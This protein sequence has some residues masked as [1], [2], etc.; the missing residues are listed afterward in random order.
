MP[1]DRKGVLKTSEL[2]GDLLLSMLPEHAGSVE[3]EGAAQDSELRDEERN[4]LLIRAGI[5][6]RVPEGGS[7]DYAARLGLYERMAEENPAAFD[8]MPPDKRALLDE[9]VAALRQQA[10]QYGENRDIGRYGA[11]QDAPAMEEI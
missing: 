10:V 11:R 9:H 2:V 6:P 8:D 3:D 4:L 1:M 7:A 5:R